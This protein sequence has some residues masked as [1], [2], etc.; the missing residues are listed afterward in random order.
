MGL[1]NK[2]VSI[3]E[4]QGKADLLDFYPSDALKLNPK[5]TQKSSYKTVA[6]AIYFIGQKMR[7]LQGRKQYLLTASWASK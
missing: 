1:T 5:E 6:P 2:G 3:G 7:H 4:M